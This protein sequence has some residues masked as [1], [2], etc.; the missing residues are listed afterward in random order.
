MNCSYFAGARL[1]IYHRDLFHRTT[2]GNDLMPAHPD[3]RSPLYDTLRQIIYNARQKAYRAI[4]HA[5]VEAY[6]N[7]GRLIVE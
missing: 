7:I 4:N 1:I 5:M 2:G 6:W 3:V